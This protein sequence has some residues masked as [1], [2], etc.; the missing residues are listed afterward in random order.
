MN[1]K[2][3]Y[4][5]ELRQ[6][7]DFNLS[8]SSTPEMAC[9]SDLDARIKYYKAQECFMASDLP[10]CFKH[11]ILNYTARL[12]SMLGKHCKRPQVLEQ[13][14]MLVSNDFKL[15][16]ISVSSLVNSL[17]NDFFLNLVIGTQ[18]LVEWLAKSDRAAD[19]LTA[20]RVST[21]FLFNNL[22]ILNFALKKYAM[23][24][25]FAKKALAESQ[26]LTET[27][28][29]NGDEK[30]TETDDHEVSDHNNNAETFAINKQQIGNVALVKV[31]KQ[32]LNI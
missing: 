16:Q 27:D 4:E 22:S 3:Q 28:E 15:N 19:D 20:C 26:R 1:S 31:R 12:G 8:S 21:C 32:I 23:G 29:T 24:C 18:S 30:K 2:S 11:L 6:L 17:R 5:R 7:I 13:L 10:A 9:A 14:E 25:L